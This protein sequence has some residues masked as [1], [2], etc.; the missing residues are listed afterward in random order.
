[1]ISLLFRSLVS[2]PAKA[3]EAA[4]L[5]LR[6]VLTFGFH[7]NEGEDSGKL[8]KKLLQTCIRPVLSDLKDYSK[9][10]RPLLRGLS[11]LLSLLSSWF[12]K[13]LGEK[14]MDHLQQWTDPSRILAVKKWKDGEEIEVATAV[15]ATFALLPLASQFVEPLVKTIMR[16]EVALPVYKYR[17]V[18]SPFRKPLARFLNS[19]AQQSVNFF[20]QRLKSPIYS[21]LFQSVLVLDE[22][23][24]L[25]AYL[26][27]NQ[28]SLMILNGCFEKPL[29][30]IR[31]E[32]RSSS[33]SSAKALSIHGIASPQSPKGENP[34]VPPG[35]MTTEALE[36]QHQGFLLIRTLLAGDGKYFAEHNDI[37]RALR[38]LWRSRGR[39]LR[40]QHEDL[41]APRFHSESKLLAH[42]LMNYAQANPSDDIDV[43]FELIRVFLPQSSAHDFGSLGRFLSNLVSSVLSPNQKQQVLGRFFSLLV[44]NSNEE[45]KVLSVQYLIFPLLLGA[46]D[47]TD[48]KDVDDALVTD[49]MVKKF[50]K[51]VLF[52]GDTPAVCGDRL[53][54][55]LLR[56]SFLIVELREAAAEEYRKEIVKYC[57]ALLKTEDSMCKSWAYVVVSRIVS[58]FE[59]PAKIVSQV[60]V[61]LLRAHQPEGRDLVRLAL[62]LLVPALP[63]RLTENE[64]KQTIEQACQVLVEEGNSSL[65]ILAHVISSILDH[66]QLFEDHHSRIVGYMMSSLAR[67]G[68]ATNSPHQHRQ[69]ALEMIK[70]ILKRDDPD[71]EDLSVVHAEA[72][73]TF[74]SRLRLVVGEPVDSRSGKMDPGLRT[75][76]TEAMQ[77]LRT[78]IGKWNVNVNLSHI[79]KA[80]CKRDKP[81]PSVTI[82]ALEILACFAEA[83]ITVMESGSEVVRD[84]VTIALE[85]SKDDETMQARLMTFTI[86][87]ASIPEAS[88]CMALIFENA[89]IGG[90]V[91]LKKAASSRA[92][93]GTRLGGRT[94]EKTQAV[95]ESSARVAQICF[96]VSLVNVLCQRREAMLARMSNPLLSLAATLTKIH[97]AGAHSKQ[98]HGVSQETTTTGSPG[99][100]HWNPTAG[101]LDSLLLQSRVDI[102]RVASAARSRALHDVPKTSACDRALVVI[103]GMF[104]LSDVTDSFSMGRKTLLH[105]VSS[106]ME[107]SDSVRVIVQVARMTGKWVLEDRPRS[108]LTIKERSSFLTK[109]SLHDFN[110]VSDDAA[111]Q[112]VADVVTML[113]S[114]LS[115]RV[116]SMSD[117]DRVAFR[118]LIIS[119]ML[120]PSS[121]ERRR[122]IC[123][124]NESFHESQS[125]VAPLHFLWRM[126][127]SDFEG[128]GGRLWL[129]M[130]VEGLTRSLQ[131]QVPTDFIDSMVTLSQSDPSICAVMFEQLFRALWSELTDGCRIRVAQ[132]IEYNL[133]RPYHAQFVRTSPA[134]SVNQK[135]SNMPRSWLRAVLQL[136]PCPTI[137]CHILTAVAE[138]Y[139]AWFE[140]IDILQRQHQ[141][142]SFGNRRLETLSALR[143]CYRMLGESAIWNS[144]TRDTCQSPMT[145]HAMVL[146]LYGAIDEASESYATL[147]EAA[148]SGSS[149]PSDEEM[150]VWEGRWLDLQKELC[151]LQVVSEFAD[152]SGDLSL[153]LECAWK[154]QDWAK[155][156]NLT[157]STG[158]LAS[159]ENGSPEIKICETLLAVVDGKKNDM[160][161]LHAQAAQLCLHRWQLLPQ[162]SDCSH[163]H[164]QLFG[165]FHRLVE[166]R[167]SGQIM[168]ETSK[169][170]S[171]KTLPE[172]KNLL[173]AWRHRLPNDFE[174]LS[175]WDELF[176][177]RSHM[178]SAITSNFH[179][180]EPN[181]LATL[182]DRPWTTV[183]LAKTARIHGN[184]DVALLLLNRVSEE[185]AM[186]VSDAYLKLREQVLAYDSPGSEVERYGGV[187]L[188]NTTNMSFFDS[189]QKAELL[190]LKGTFL[191]S[192]GGTKEANQSYCNALQICPTHGSAWESWGKLCC[193]IG[194]AAEKQTDKET[195]DDGSKESSS[196]QKST[197]YFAQAMG[198]Y[199]EAIL[200]GSSRKTRV[201]VPKL[202]WMLSK[203]SSST[204]VL[205]TTFRS[206]ATQLPA[207]VWL[208]WTPQLLTS[209]CRQEASAIKSVLSTIVKAYPQ[210]VYHPLR[211]FFLDRRDVERMRSPST[212]GQSTPMKSVSLAEELMSTLRRAHPSLWTSLES[213]LEEFLYKFRLSSEEEMLTT[214]VALLERAE[215]QTGIAG[216]AKEDEIAVSLWKTL[217]RIATKYF[218]PTETTSTRRD[219]RSTRTAAFKENNR[220]AFEEDFGVSSS[221]SES[222]ED[223]AIPDV[224]LDGLVEKMRSWKSRLEVQVMGS[225]QS[226]SLIEYSRPLAMFCVNEAPD[227]W[228]GYV[229]SDCQRH[230][231]R[232]LTHCCE[233]SM[234][235]CTRSVQD[236]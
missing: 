102:S 135:H 20:F 104:E 68:L 115:G 23:K 236:Q 81:V 133:S 5:A 221:A 72:I 156:R 99:V 216:K 186:N 136:Q 192:I 209:L 8:P 84:V 201:N 60:F 27:N 131:T 212:S 21:E 29:A 39:F 4:S 205:C 162:L 125:C 157:S 183:R 89:L 52:V 56:L 109:L 40:L 111:A 87:A 235:S 185:K 74:L 78:V 213:M 24:E 48:H 127:H 12:N 141:G 173:N 225:F 97:L 195:P 153:Q 117:T 211:A 194:L 167:E 149:S 42:F 51:D 50:V 113:I 150:D 208:P 58:S 219:D 159:I 155:V 3:V 26:C 30:I 105:V 177:W 210:A 189:A 79:E 184:R 120:H 83:D 53:R 140:V 193:Q 57:W 55:E 31:S 137:D 132:A 124:F 154:S 171:R 160:D 161:N 172:L 178:Y 188:I 44:E 114:E 168:E 226:T 169:H 198:C 82:A 116:G 217:G 187:N 214:L 101:V 14:L 28:C 107:S 15:V 130:L 129:P 232:Q 139:N 128:L 234:R 76:E 71:G 203:D 151:Q 10:S 18:V 7:H 64:L 98:R 166:I 75:L 179:Y 1:M 121:D 93:D 164:S 13:T 176:S 100:L 106:L 220:E 218:R 180:A 222:Q 45:L 204:G 175:S 9:L 70:F 152:A 119:C 158:L 227:L 46:A 36:L 112:P 62:K 73:A 85:N 148:G 49:D 223:V 170:S 2:Q 197:Q 59:T 123:M 143:Y 43:L 200:L 202:L 94:R 138:N 190:R 163:S 230:Y 35:S 80:V 103:L 77:L 229:Y 134:S 224:T 41:V 90:T 231:R 38:W 145:V 6:D 144:V 233:Q 142:L 11:Q 174:S 88:D 108:P 146:D 191:V 34:T 86:A 19:H 37:V 22:C 32:K 17:C 67:L 207:W 228:P 69:T 95:D 25:R 182:H 61:S 165:F 110:C 16:L 122:L 206:R 181:M 63:S 199:I 47:A 65:P 118:R 91:E 215:A 66:P 96:I 147:M 196:S 92:G 126:L 33:S 54:I